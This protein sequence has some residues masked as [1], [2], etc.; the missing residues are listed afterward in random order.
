MHE[1]KICQMS[2]EMSGEEVE[3]HNLIKEVGMK[4]RLE[5]LG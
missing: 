3:E 2:G 4:S 5:D 1:R